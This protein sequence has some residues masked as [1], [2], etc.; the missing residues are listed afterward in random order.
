MKAGVISVSMCVLCMGISYDKTH[1][2][3]NVPYI[4]I[5]FHLQIQH[6]SSNYSEHSII[7]TLLGT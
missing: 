7:C 5:C 2:R 1:L 6:R 4:I 3:D